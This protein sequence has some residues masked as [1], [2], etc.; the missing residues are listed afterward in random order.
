MTVV[1]IV[2]TTMS[3]GYT[4]CEIRVSWVYLFNG[5]PGTTHQVMNHDDYTMSTLSYS[6]NVVE[7]FVW[8]TM[9]NRHNSG[10]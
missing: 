3:Y 6:G 4:Q 10:V 1:M 5:L 9:Y 8:S 7:R 2:S